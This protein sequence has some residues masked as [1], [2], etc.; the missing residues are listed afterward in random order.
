MKI[1]WVEATNF[2]KFVGTV[3]VE[4]IG[5]GLNVLVGPN[6]M[7]KSTLM[8]AI[9]GVVFQK[10]N[11]QSKEVKSFNHL[12]NRTYP[13]S[14]LASISTAKAGPL[15]SAL[16]ARPGRPG[17]RVRMAAATRARRPKRNYSAC[18]ASRSG[19]HHRAR[20]LGYALG[21]AEP[22]LRRPGSRRA[23]APDTARLSRIAGRRSHRRG[24]RPTDPDGHRSRARRP[25]QREG[26]TREV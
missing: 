12:F 22:L 7:G 25:R 21:A 9:N 8:E 17:C 5:D 1:R 14:R 19:A 16:Q 4:G 2:R 18:S 11:S 24:A 23:R 6:E 26:S 10:S 20:H 15:G 13:R 3:R